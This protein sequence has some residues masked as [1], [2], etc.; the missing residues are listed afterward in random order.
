MHPMTLIV[1]VLRGEGLPP[2]ERTESK[3][4]SKPEANHKIYCIQRTLAM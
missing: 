1:K 2:T 4:G 3:M